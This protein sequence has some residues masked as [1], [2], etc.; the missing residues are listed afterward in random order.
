MSGNELVAGYRAGAENS[1]RRQLMLNEGMIGAGQA[2]SGMLKTALDLDQLHDLNMISDA[3]YYTQ[4]AEE[5]KAKYT[6]G[7]WQKKQKREEWEKEN[8]PFGSMT[9]AGGQEPADAPPALRDV[10]KMQIGL[11]TSWE[12]SAIQKAQEIEESPLSPEEKQRAVWEMNDLERSVLKLPVYSQVERQQAEYARLKYKWASGD[13]TDQER[14]AYDKMSGAFAP[15]PTYAQIR[16]DQELADWTNLRVKWL[17]YVDKN[18]IIESDLSPE[19]VRAKQTEAFGSKLAVVR[20]ESLSE[21]YGKNITAKSTEKLAK[22]FWEAKQRLQAQI[23]QNDRMSAAEKASVLQ[24][25]NTAVRYED[26][27]RIKGANGEP[28]G[29][30]IY[31]GV[32]GFEAQIDMEETKLARERMVNEAEKSEIDRRRAQLELEGYE[33][34]IARAAREVQEQKDKERRDLEAKKDYAKF[35]NDLKNMA[36]NGFEGIDEVTGASLMTGLSRLLVADATSVTADGFLGVDVR[37]QF[38]N[39]LTKLVDRYGKRMKK[40]EEMEDA[41]EE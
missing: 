41:D 29:D 39:M 11:P 2:I 28:I 40:Q 6:A 14:E 12:E 10:E 37:E 4:K 18:G 33:S 15:T 5:A 22:T 1:N 38:K 17:E 13:M 7:I 35:V 9:W 8:A 26:L 34:P 27:K 32:K 23:I 30:S 20:Y 24:G 31:A 36:E 16:A 21:H 19:E 3:D 25:L